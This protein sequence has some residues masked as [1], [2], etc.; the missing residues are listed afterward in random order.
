MSLVYEIPKRGDGVRFPEPARNFMI[1]INPLIVKLL[2]LSS[3]LLLTGCFSL[4]FDSDTET[5]LVKPANEKRL[6]HLVLCWLKDS[7][8]ESH[9]EQIID[10]TSTFCEIPGVIDARAGKVVTS[11][12]KIVDD[13]FDVGILI[14]TKDQADLKKYLDHPIHQNAKRDV[15][16]SLVKRILVYDFED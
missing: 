2:A 7:G 6:H 12:R 9:R 10:L 13:S 3:A 16:Q 15:L 14:V 1:K 5:N 11:D 4:S 8:N